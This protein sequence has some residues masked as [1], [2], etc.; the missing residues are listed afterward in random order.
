MTVQEAYEG[1]PGKRPYPSTSGLFR[2]VAS[3]DPGYIHFM[4]RY[5]LFAVLPLLVFSAGGCATSPYRHGNGVESGNVLRLKPDEPQFEP[6][7]ENTFVDVLGWVFGIPSKII[8]LDSRADNHKIS[9]STVE[10]MREY[11]QSNSLT[12]VKVRVNQYSPGG[13]WSRLFR[14][15]S[16][17]ALWRY[18]FGTLSTLFYTILPG[19]V[20]GGDNYN[21]YTDTISLYSNHK[22]IA[23]HEG[24]HAKDFAPRK[25]KGT[26]AFFYMLPFA[27]LYAEARASNDA[28]SYLHAQPSARGELEG[29]RIL[30]PAYA[31]YIG[32]NAQY[33]FPY[34]AVYFGALVPG[35]IL[36]HWKGSRVE[37][38]RAAAGGGDSGLG[39]GAE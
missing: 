26:Y 35:H 19:R 39:E 12:N 6:G 24:G 34:T 21:P 14:N 4:S 5:A 23:I 1:I 8:L 38:R 10:Y 2:L 22:A 29:Y 3:R 37:S 27:S 11:L 28:I 17:G 13:E 33:I 16:V 31:T 32:G 18:T 20:F 7:R 25:Y 9:E 30:Y 15:K 36:G